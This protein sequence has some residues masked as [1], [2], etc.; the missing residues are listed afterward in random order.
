MYLARLILNPRNRWVQEDLANPYDLHRRLM[1]SYP[2]DLDMP[3]EERV[4][5]RVDTDA[6]TGVPT[7]LLQSFQPP[8]WEWLDNGGSYLLPTHRLPPG[9]RENPALKSFEL[10]LQA[11]QKLAFRLRA[12]PTVKRQGSRYGLIQEKKQRDW[13][14]RK[15][16][17]NGFNVVGV[18][19]IQEGQTHAWKPKRNGEKRRLTFRSV[20]YQGILEVADPEQLWRGVKRGIGSGKAFGFGLLSLAPPSS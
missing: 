8:A 13:L 7:V 6:R 11:G 19:L 16:E 2:D 15:G 10:G 4:L 12:N 3:S 9:V 20:I 1:R 5:Y 18:D 17:R 14:A